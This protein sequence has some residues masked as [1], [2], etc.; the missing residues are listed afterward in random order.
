MKMGLVMQEPTLFNYSVHEN[1]LYGNMKATNSMIRESAQVANALEFVESAGI[2]TAFSDTPEALLKALESNKSQALEF[3]KQEEYDKAI[4]ALTDLKKQG[5][6]DFVA[7]DD[8]L[9]S[10]PKDLKDIELNNGFK[11]N[12]GVKG[13]KLSGGQKQ[14]IAIARAVVR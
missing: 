12:C 8:I 6:A 4:V 10:R 13:S 7:I 14:R 2:E 11:T 9:D 1:I 5:I 3:M